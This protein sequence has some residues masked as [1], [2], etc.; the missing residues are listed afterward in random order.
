MGW[1]KVVADTIN[2]AAALAIAFVVLSVHN[3]IRDQTQIDPVVLA[4]MNQEEIIVIIAIVFIA[5]AYALNLM[6]QIYLI[7]KQDR[8][9]QMHEK[10]ARGKISKDVFQILQDKQKTSRT[11]Q[12]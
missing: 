11:R 6:D 9:H 1:I 10:L 7:Y 4:Q 12:R 5:V 8:Q 3:K 2:V